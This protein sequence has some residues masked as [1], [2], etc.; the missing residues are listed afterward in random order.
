MNWDDRLHA[1]RARKDVDRPNYLAIF[2]DPAR[3]A[4]ENGWSRRYFCRNRLEKKKF[5]PVLPVEVSE[6]R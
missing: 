2:C 3:V 4:P 5:A 1:E 6:K